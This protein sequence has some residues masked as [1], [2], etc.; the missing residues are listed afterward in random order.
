MASDEEP[1]S[2]DETAD[3]ADSSPSPVIPRSSA[4][5]L[6]LIRR[7]TEIEQELKANE[8]Q[9]TEPPGDK[10]QSTDEALAAIALRH[11]RLKLKQRRQDMKQRRWLAKWALRIVVCQLAIADIF[12]GIYL[13]ANL[14]TMDGSVM[15]AWLSATVVEVVGILWVIARN[16]F[17]FRD[18]SVPTTKRDG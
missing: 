15:I 12:F 5:L 17:P 10:E 11:Q 14:T 2:E 7:A 16:L 3:D 1:P 8:P 6:A 18:K 4:R 9:P 13:I